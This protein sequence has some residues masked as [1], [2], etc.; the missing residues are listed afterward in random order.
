MGQVLGEISYDE[1]KPGSDVW[2]T[3]DVR[4]QYIV[5]N[6]LRK[7]GR[8][9]VV[10][11]PRN[12]ELNNNGESHKVYAGDILAMASVLH[13]IQTNLFHQLAKRIGKVI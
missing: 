10:I 8:A 7:V 5:E 1:P 2:L 3:L 11:A 9:A 6:A 12:Y 13:M 4:Y